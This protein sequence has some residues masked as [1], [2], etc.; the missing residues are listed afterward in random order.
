MDMDDGPA[1][2]MFEITD[3]DVSAII[4][5]DAYAGHVDALRVQ[6]RDAL[7]AAA[8]DR[9]C[10]LGQVSVT[11]EKEPDGAHVIRM[12]APAYKQVGVLPWKTP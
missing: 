7:E 3:L 1:E 2:P 12:T 10:T 8:R 5:T 11:V 6:M 4:D 9:G